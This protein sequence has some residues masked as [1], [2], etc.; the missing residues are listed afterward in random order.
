ML[1]FNRRMWNLVK[2][3][4]IF[5]DQFIEL[6]IN[7][8]NP[9][10]GVLKIQE[11]PCDSM[12]R[13]ETVKG[14]LLEFQQSK[15]QGS[16]PDYGALLRSDIGIATEEDLQTSSCIRFHPK[17]IVHFKI[18]DERKTFY[19]YGVSLV[20]PARGPAHQLRLLEDAMVVYRLSRAPERRI[21]YIDVGD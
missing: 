16:G 13:I 15:L 8:E 21:F 14:K 2:N 18:G 11:L 4:C 9:K 5:G 17:Q 19:P 7:K 3:V 12:Y 1:N 10:H 6:I 20:E